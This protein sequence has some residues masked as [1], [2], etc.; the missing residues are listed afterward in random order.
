MDKN[1]KWLLAGIILF[2]SYTLTSWSV[3][4]DNKVYTNGSNVA[5]HNWEWAVGEVNT[6]WG[7][8]ITFNLTNGTYTV[9]GAVFINDVFIDGSN[10][11]HTNILCTGTLVLTNGCTIRNMRGITALDGS[12][13]DFHI[14]R[15]NGYIGS[16][17]NFGD[18]CMLS[19][20]M[21]GN[22]TCGSKAEITDNIISNGTLTVADN[23]TIASNNIASGSSGILACGNNNDINNNMQL[24]IN[25]NGSSN[26]L[27]DCINITGLNCSGN[28]NT[29]RDSSFIGANALISGNGNNINNCTIS[30]G[31]NGLRITGTGNSVKKCIISGC[32]L[33]GIMISGTNTTVGSSLSADRNY[34]YSNGNCGIA[35]EGAMTVHIEA[36]YIGTTNRYIANSL[37]N[38][39]HGIW[40]ND[41]QDV[42]IGQN[43]AGAQNLI[44][45]NYGNGICYDELSNL[46][47]N[48][49]ITGNVIKENMQHG[50]NINGGNNIQIMGNY[51]G[52]DESDITGQGNT[53]DGI[54]IV[55]STGIQI[56]SSLSAG[57]NIISGNSGNG[58]YFDGTS[59]SNF[60]GG[61]VQGNYIGTTRNGD[62]S[63]PNAANGIL[64]EN[65]WGITIG[66]SDTGQKNIISGNS[67]YGINIKQLNGDVPGN[68]TVYGNYIGTDKDGT[69]IVPNANGIFCSGINNNIGGPLPGMGNLISGNTRNGIIIGKSDSNSATYDNFIL[70]NYIGTDKDGL[71]PLGNGECGIIATSSVYNCRIGST[72]GVGYQAGNIICDNGSDGISII[73][74]FINSSNTIDGN[75]IGVGVDGT[76]S[77]GNGR[78]GILLGGTNFQ[79]S[80][81]IQVGENEGNVISGNHNDGINIRYLSESQILNNKIGM[82]ADGSIPIPNNGNGITLGDSSSQVQIGNSLTN[83]ANWIGGNSGCGILAL[84]YKN[85]ICGNYIGTAPATLPGFGINSGIAGI[86]ITNISPA[87]SL[88]ITIGGS[89]QHENVINGNIGIFIQ[90][91]NN[92]G[93]INIDG[94]WIGFNPDI[95]TATTNMTTGILIDNAEHIEIGGVISGNKIGGTTLSG[96]KIINS[97]DIELNNNI[98]G[99]AENTGGI[100]TNIG[101]G[102]IISSNSSDI[103]TGE[104]QGEPT[105]NYLAG[106]N[107]GLL[108]DNVTE[109]HAPYITVGLAPNGS[110]P[111][112]RSD[113][114]RITGGSKNSIGTY[115]T[116]NPSF[117]AGNTGVGIHLIDTDQPVIFSTFV[118]ISTN[119]SAAVPN[120]A[121]GILLHDTSNAQIGHQTYRNII[122]GNQNYGIRIENTGSATNN[123]SNNFIGLDSQGISSIPNYGDGIIIVNAGHNTI[124]ENRI[125]GNQNNGISITGTSAIANT[126]SQNRIWDNGV[127]GI[128]LGSGGIT[129]DFQ[130]SDIGPNGLQNTPTPTN[131]WRGST[132]VNGLFNSKPDTDYRIEYFASDSTNASGIVEGQYYIDTEWITT[133]SQGNAPLELYAG[134]TFPIGM[135]ITA[136]ATETDTGN[137]SEFSLSSPLVVIEKA[138][139]A[140]TN[141]IADYYEA[142]YPDMAAH[143]EGA[144]SDYDG[145]GASDLD[146]YIALSNPEDDTDFFHVTINSNAVVV[147][148]TSEQRYYH[149]NSSTNLQYWTVIN[150]AEGTGYAWSTPI[151]PT[152]K[153]SRT[154]FRAR[155]FLESP[156]GE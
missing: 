149:L 74:T 142:L 156:P 12:H 23:S 97:N 57:R 128:S 83:G 117:V 120:Q 7:S 90:N 151:P 126:I 60:L 20:N 3:V 104:Y 5:V 69:N 25:L 123:I 45:G 35:L 17:T 103:T 109:C 139:D 8:E 34:I 80:Y 28:N 75:Y 47:K 118:G 92:I 138:V 18:Q 63:L 81:H 51:I 55:N 114:I 36:N 154:M 137:T 30:G 94:N 41:S 42:H 53:G 125:S 136:T 148:N 16:I 108:L 122:S 111:G 78:H 6:N 38:G 73:T 29:I 49:W 119:G 1:K 4:V 76:T 143:T 141:G 33:N 144:N 66:G 9:P 50:I 13:D 11:S 79:T 153:S 95:A 24:I 15:N 43:T 54:H 150:K 130:D 116:D 64:I 85:L 124:S 31:A 102:I 46:N 65:G 93:S 100:V 44:R 113:G 140:N 145:D 67:D 32:A 88:K 147:P 86:A 27:H 129:N 59:N 110:I 89:N 152:N 61:S 71:Q 134:K 52:T 72:N 48:I 99:C 70:G 19:G 155:V 87:N 14:I 91:I 132:H 115:T 96:I 106:N 107:I 135:F 39:S 112:N 10:G 2:F 98:I 127:R 37:G 82:S 101:D 21:L 84:G 133:D 58:I 40:I 131:A 77:L 22:V 56:G 68:I 62:A 26:Q 121:G 146:E 105:R